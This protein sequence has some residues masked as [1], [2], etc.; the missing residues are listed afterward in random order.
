MTTENFSICKF[1][2]FD[3][4]FSRLIRNLEFERRNMW[5]PKIN[6][7]VFIDYMEF[8]TFFKLINAN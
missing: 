2:C 5:F 6:N 3:F 4:S 1:T 7:Q 8:M